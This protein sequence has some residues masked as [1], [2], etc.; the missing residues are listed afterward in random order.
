MNG[1]NNPD[2][3][4]VVSADPRVQAL[5]EVVANRLDMNSGVST[6]NVDKT[7]IGR[8]R[9]LMQIE[10][11]AAENAELKAA[12]LPMAARKAS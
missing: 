1:G 6:A 9:V 7:N 12:A 2:K 8:I 5:G 10:V 3:R 11:L 4:R